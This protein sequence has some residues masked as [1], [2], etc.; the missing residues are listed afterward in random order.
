[1]S[2]GPRRFIEDPEW[3]GAFEGL[4]QEHGKIEGL[5]GDVRAEV[6]AMIAASVAGAVGIAAASAAGSAISSAGGAG[7]ATTA[8]S[9]VS[10]LGSAGAG[11][12]ATALGS[13][14]GAATALGTTAATAVGA[15]A[16]AAAA[17][18]ASGTLAAG[19][20]S[21]AAV[22]LVPKV[23]AALSLAGAMT[24]GSVAVVK[25]TQSQE[26]R[27]NGAEVER[28]VSESGPSDDGANSSL[29]GV[30]SSKVP[31]ST[32]RALLG[33]DGV[34]TEPA[35]MVPTASAEEGPS[36][37]PSASGVA[38][39]LSQ[40]V[41]KSTATG[42]AGEVRL[43]GRARAAL[44]ENREYAWTLLNEYQRRYPSG[45]LRAEYEVLVRRVQTTPVDEQVPEE[46]EGAR[47][48][49]EPS[50]PQAH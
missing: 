20:A 18:G 14:A 10:A 8:A 38:D 22:G 7:T 43:L 17:L 37:S 33:S 47:A 40:P 44:S 41:K 9:S 35:K 6:A 50:S 28:T 16:G 21:L 5:P 11:A 30:S 31:G 32:E 24:A 34:D 25:S 26:A 19:G 23:I 27:S 42:L 2:Q 4:L 48:K 12:S 46:D 39:P 45:A 1:M 3:G 29:K 15:S 49:D 36:T 13:T